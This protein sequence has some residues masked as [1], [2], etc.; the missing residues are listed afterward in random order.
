MSLRKAF[1]V[2]AAFS[3][4]SFLYATPLTKEKLDKLL[5]LFEQRLEECMKESH[6][7]GLAIAIIIDNQV[8]YIKGFGEKRIGEKSPITPDT[9][10]QVASLSKPMSSTVIAALVGENIVE[11]DSRVNQLDPEFQLMVP[12]VTTQLTLRDLLS[13]RSGLPDQAGDLLEDLGFDQAT[14]LH[15]LCLD[16]NSGFR[17]KFQYTNFGYTEA[18]LA[19]AKA[20]GTTWDVLVRQKLIDP[21]HMDSTSTKFADFI[22]NPNR[23]D[24]HFIQE[25][26]AKPLFQRNSDSQTPAGGFSTNMNDFTKWMILQLSEGKYDGKQIISAKA[27]EETHIPSIT[28]GDNDFY[29]MGWNIKYGKQGEKVISH[30][31]GFTLGA[32]TYTKLIPSEKFGITVFANAAVSGLPE[33]VIDI[34]MDLKETGRVNQNWL[35]IWNE[36]FELLYG[37]KTKS[38]PTPQNKS[39]PLPLKAY[40]GSYSNA[41]FGELNIVE[42]EGKLQLTIG[43]LA[44]TFI[45][46]FLN[47][48]AFFFSAQTENLAGFYQVIFTVDGLGMANQVFINAFNDN[49]WGTFKKN[50]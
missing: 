37:V 6:T 11:W 12:W 29:G 21:L 38:L 36:R 49:G 7:P 28:R 50:K 41:Y 4:S 25:G 42:K 40:T 27:L 47:R 32:R 30:S 9:L 18:A 16:P 26:V 14:I 2:T 22:N 8:A 3:L 19:A 31:G 44:K 13:H 43:P 23:A 45:L 48:D 20:A 34:F 35:A 24:L 33:A 5:P 1:L 15:Q 10:F 46:N 39:E 17:A